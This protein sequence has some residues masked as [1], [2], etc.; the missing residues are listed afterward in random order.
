M[1]ETKKNAE[2]TP[3]TVVFTVLKVLGW[4]LLFL[5]ALSLVYPF[6]W[7]I[8]NSLKSGKFFMQDSGFS[9][10]PKGAAIYNYIQ[11]WT[12]EG[13]MGSGVTVEGGVGSFFLNSVWITLAS[14]ALTILFS[15]MA[16]YV[17]AHFQFALHGVVYGLAV[18][19]FLLPSVGTLAAFLNMMRTLN[20]DSAFGLVIYYSSGIN[21]SM[22]ILY[23]CFKGIP[24]DYAEAAEMDGANKV[25]IFF[26]IMMPMA[27][28]A[29]IP[30]AVMAAINIWNDYFIPEMLLENSG[31]RTLAIGLNDV[32]GVASRKSNMPLMFAAIMISCAPMIIL[33]LILHKQIMEN[34]M[35]GGLKG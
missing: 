31:V 29:L 28:S 16:A 12:G 33:Y 19:T 24:K 9:A 32:L 22:L 34:M 1:E 15:S 4:L 14:V 5:Y 11:A 35:L 26:E 6:V 30:V 23:G 17:L 20:L 13:L 7:V 25:Q 18:A 2:Q 27:T 8:V 3:L 21:S 10:D